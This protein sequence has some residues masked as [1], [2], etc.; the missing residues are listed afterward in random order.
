MVDTKKYKNLILNKISLLTNKK[1][2]KEVD[3]DGDEADKIQGALILCVLNE[4]TGRTRKT[5]GELNNALLKIQ[6]CDY[7]TC[8]ECGEEIN[9]KR[10][11]VCPEAK[12]CIICAE[13]IERESKV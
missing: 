11:N 6:N 7:G 10:L 12:Y 13:L 9:E 3:L 1:I 8:E 2:D 5:L 4:Y